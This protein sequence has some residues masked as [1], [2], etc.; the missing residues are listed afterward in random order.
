MLHDQRCPVLITATLRKE[1]IEARA[2]LIAE[3]LAPREPGAE[4]V[5][6]PCENDVPPRWRAIEAACPARGATCLRPLV[7]RISVPV[8]GL[9]AGA[10]TTRTHHL[11]EWLVG[12][13]ERRLEIVDALSL[14][15][16]FGVV[17]DLEMRLKRKLYMVNGAHL[18]LGIRGAMLGRRSLRVT[19]GMPE[20]AYDIAQLHVY[21]SIGLAYAGCN[22]ADNGDYGRDHLLAYCEVADEV[23]RITKPIKRADLRPFLATLEE[24]LSRPAGMTAAAQSEFDSERR[25]GDWLAPYRRVFNR[26]ETALRQLSVYADGKAVGRRE[27]RLDPDIDREA[28]SLYRQCLRSWER[29]SDVERRVEGLRTTLAV[30]RAGLRRRD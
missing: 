28:L 9:A 1:G 6:M 3:L 4:T 25:L 5:V 29:A 20:N 19:A 18:A 10:R 26:I 17:D 16:C 2:P 7:N 11:G 30:H 24:R 8:D 14:N 15:A 12:P 13:S 23:R 22:L 27:L 21:M